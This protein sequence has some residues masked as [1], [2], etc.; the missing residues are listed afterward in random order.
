LT[1][2][3]TDTNRNSSTGTQTL[4]VNDNTAPVITRTPTAITYTC[5]SAVP[6][7]SASSV[8]ETDNISGTVSV[9]VGDVITNLTCT[10]HYTITRTWTA[11]DICSNSSS[12]SQ[13]ITVNDNIAPVITG[14]PAAIAYTCASAVPLASASSV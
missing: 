11:T 3:A 12:T 4:T 7:A 2:K 5:A 6:V 1:Y 9:T 14:T 8:S 10:H 13:I